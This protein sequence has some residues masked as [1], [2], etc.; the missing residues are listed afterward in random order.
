MSRR[1]HHIS[2]RP[3]RRRRWFG[4][5]GSGF[6][7]L[8]PKRWRARIFLILLFLALLPGLLLLPFRWLPVVQTTFMV[9]SRV[10]ALMDDKP[11][12]RF[13]RDWEPM[14]RISPKLAQAVIAAEDQRFFEHSGFDLEAMRKAFAHNRVKKKVRGGSTISQQLAKNLFLWSGRSYLRKGLEAYCTI[15][16]ELLWPKQRILEV[17]LNVVE[18]GDQTYG[19][20]AAALRY[21]GKPAAR[22]SAREAA[23]MAAVL[24]S[25]KRWSVG[26]PGPYVQRRAA[27]IQAQMAPLPFNYPKP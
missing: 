10:A 9:N 22:L 2:A 5:L 27:R 16:I 7:A 24:P 17:Y 20:E 18:F 12:P 8:W 15:W 6:K 4:R 14:A 19:A 1:E 3:K 25:P 26:K 11:R 23:L 21:F 13:V